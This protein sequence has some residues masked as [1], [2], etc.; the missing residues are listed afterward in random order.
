[1]QTFYS[2]L[3]ARTGAQHGQNALL[4]KPLHEELTHSVMRN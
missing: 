2:K 3:Q 4:Q 1:M